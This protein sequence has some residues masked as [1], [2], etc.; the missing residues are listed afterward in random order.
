MG[1]TGASSIAKMLDGGSVAVAPMA[2]ENFKDDPLSSN[3]SLCFISSG[4]L[5]AAAATFVV[6]PIG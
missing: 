2:A 1:V 5:A 3:G 4:G 6:G